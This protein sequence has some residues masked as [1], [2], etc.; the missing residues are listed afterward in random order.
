MAPMTRDRSRADGVPS[1]LNVEYYRQRASMSLIIT[2]GI[3]PSDDGQGYLLTPGVYADARIAGW[4]DVLEKLNRT[5][6]AA[7][8][9]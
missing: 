7:Y 8:L 9:G 1:E 6:R 3:Q 4:T 2:E 5:V